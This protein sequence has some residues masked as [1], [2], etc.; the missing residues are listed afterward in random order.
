MASFVSRAGQKLEHALQHFGVEVVGHICAD[1]G[2]NTGG[3]VDCLL[4]RGASKVYAI[5]TGYGA[6]AWKLRNDPRVV[7]M[8]RHNAMHVQLPEPVSRITIDVAWTKQKNIL[9]A[10]R[11][12][13]LDDGLIITLIKPHYEAD[14]K[15]LRRGVLPPEEL[16]AVIAHVVQDIRA[17]GLQVKQTASSPITGSKG[18][19]EILALLLA[20]D[21]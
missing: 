2:S 8:E 1:L 21:D 18:N 5:D 20:T 12:M 15:L 13:L 19:A 10:A 3:F 7:V 4:Q 9:P 14:P 16:D 17:C 6:L 11:R